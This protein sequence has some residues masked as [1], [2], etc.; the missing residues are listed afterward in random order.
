MTEDAYSWYVYDGDND[1]VYTISKITGTIEVDCNFKM[2]RDWRQDDSDL[3]RIEI[4][5]K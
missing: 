2:T 5:N 4:S 1:L 3:I